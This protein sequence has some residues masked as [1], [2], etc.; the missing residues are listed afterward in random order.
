[1]SRSARSFYLT[2]LVAIV[3]EWLS[4]SHRGRRHCPGAYVAFALV[5]FLATWPLWMLA[6][7][8]W[9]FRRRRS[10]P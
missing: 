10:L 3:A 6:G 4:I 5:V 1:M 7:L 8:A 2:A 9:S